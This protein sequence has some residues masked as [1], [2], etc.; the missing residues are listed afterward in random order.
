MNG[1]IAV[2]GAN[3]QALVFAALAAK[4]GFEVTVI[5]QKPKNE[6]AY[7]WTDDMEAAAL[8]DA[9]LPKPPEDCYVDSC[10]PVFV[11]P[12]SSKRVEITDAGEPQ[13]LALKR[14]RFNA[15]LEER[16]IDAGARIVYER[17]VEKALHDGKKI[18]GLQVDNGGA[19]SCDLLVDCG[20]VNSAIREQLADSFPITGRIDNG[21]KFFVRRTVF[22]RPAG[23]EYKYKKQIYLKHLGER[24]ISWCNLAGDGKYADALIGRIGS[25]NDENYARALDDLKKDNSIIGGKVICDGEKLQIP[26]RKPLPRMTLPGYVLLGDS[27]CMTI[28]LIGS[29]MA[30]SIRAA[31]MLADVISNPRGEAFSQENLYCYQLAFMKRIGSE[32]AFINTMK[33][34]LLSADNG[35]ITLM[36][37][38]GLLACV[39]ASAEGAS[40]G[41]PKAVCRIAAKRPPLLI[42]LINLLIKA[43][44]AK[45]TALSMPEE[46]DEKQFDLWRNKYERI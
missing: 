45:K 29:G 4:A 2:V 9:G 10:T 22:E 12:N 31:K 18:I 21:D 15:W 44:R 34:W 3:Q 26:L 37:D 43:M 33:N 28:P 38:S 1:K 36:I 5:E 32:H 25:L 16:A 20:G 7:G 46:Y 24:G 13:D 27:A 39:V 40:G 14:R 42:K 23:S 6:V 17:R 35:D 30:S 19:V 8:A 41:M 11:A